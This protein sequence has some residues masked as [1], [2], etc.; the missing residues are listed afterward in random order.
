MT[1]T[2][3][4]FLFSNHTYAADNNSVQSM[5]PAYTAIQE[6]LTKDDLALAKTE[7]QKLEKMSAK[8][9]DPELLKVK[10]SLSVFTKETK[11]ADA[12]GEFKKLSAPFVAWMEKNKNAAYEV[13]YCPMAKAKWVQKKGSVINPYYGQEMLQCGEKVL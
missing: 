6:A 1:M 9:K 10:A 8:W 5:L 13:Y 11:I 7:A 2:I 4:T 3:S 12:R